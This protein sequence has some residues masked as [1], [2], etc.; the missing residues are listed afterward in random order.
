MDRTGQYLLE[1]TRREMLVMKTFFLSEMVLLSSKC[2]SVE[3]TKSVQ[4]SLKRGERAAAGLQTKP[5]PTGL[6]VRKRPVLPFLL[7]QRLSA[8]LQLLKVAHGGSDA[9]SC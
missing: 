4:S 3:S 1:V 2:K 7:R 9:S 6:S 5:T 8:G